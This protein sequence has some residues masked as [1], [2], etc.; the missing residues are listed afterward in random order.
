[1]G[2][3]ERHGGLLAALRAHGDGFVLYE[4]APGTHGAARRLAI[5]AASRLIRQILLRKESLFAGGK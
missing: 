4:A 3:P 5:L 1:L 2:G